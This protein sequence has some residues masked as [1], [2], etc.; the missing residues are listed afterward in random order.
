MTPKVRLNSNTRLIKI[1]KSEL[2]MPW[3]FVL[4]ASERTGLCLSGNIQFLQ[5]LFTRLVSLWESISP[6]NGATS[7]RNPGGSVLKH[8]HFC[9]CLR[10]RDP[11]AEPVSV[12]EASAF[13]NS[14]C[15]R[16]GAWGLH[17]QASHQYV[18]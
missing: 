18:L 7:T 10:I 15:C 6:I 12:S 13:Q 1:S 5:G 8:K 17:P 4:C 14:T 2:Q 11:E 9:K 16:L 3:H